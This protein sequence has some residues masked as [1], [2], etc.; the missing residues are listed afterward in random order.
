MIDMP[1]YI[2]R[3]IIGII[4]ISVNASVMGSFVVFRGTAFMVAG[5]SHAA[6]AGAAF[7]VLLSVNY[8]INFDPMLGALLSALALALLSAHSTG[9]FSREKMNINIGVGF[10]LSMSL[11]LLII[12]MI[13]EASSRVWSLLVGD[14]LLLTSKDLV[15]ILLMTIVSLVIVAVLYNDLIFLSFDPESALAYGIR[16]GALNYLLLALISVAVVIV[17]RGVGA[18]LVYAMLVA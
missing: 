14:I 18:I 5:A 1:E 2:L 3:A 16:A 9:P 4:L 10:A 13:R 12:T 7:A 11:A 6:L 15:Q 17:M 8:G